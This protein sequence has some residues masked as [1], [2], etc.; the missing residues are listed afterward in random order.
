MLSDTTLYNYSIFSFKHKRRKR[1]ADNL[2][3]WS[4]YI[5]NKKTCTPQNNI[6][7]YYAIKNAL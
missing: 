7:K 6:Y 1:L 2:S 5:Y 4:L 3:R